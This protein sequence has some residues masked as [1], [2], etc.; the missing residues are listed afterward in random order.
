LSVKPVFARGESVRSINITW[1]SR[2][3]V[4]GNKNHSVETV[5]GTHRSLCED[6]SVTCNSCGLKGVIQTNE[7]YA[8]V[9]WQTDE[10]MSA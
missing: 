4:C 10:E 3:R 2:C 5:R 8:F 7:G 6:D 9:L 1:L